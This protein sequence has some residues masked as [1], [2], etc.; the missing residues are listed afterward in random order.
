MRELYA[1]A[2]AGEYHRVLTHDIAAAKRRESDR[3]GLS[4]ADVAFAR[5]KGVR[6]EIN[7][8]PGGRSL[9]Q[10][11]RG[12]RRRVDLVLVVHFND[13]DVIGVTERARSAFDKL[14]QHVDADAHVR[15]VDDRDDLCVCAEL[16]LL[17]RVETGRSDDGC[18]TMLCT[19][20]NVR[21]R[22]GGPREVDQHIGSMYG[23]INV[24]PHEHARR[25]AKTFT[26]IM[27]EKCAV[28]DVERTHDV[29]IARLERCLDQR[30][31]H[32]PTCAG[33]RQLQRHDSIRE[34]VMRNAA[35]IKTRPSEYPK[36][37]RRIPCHQPTAPASWLFRRRRD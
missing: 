18:A 32:T 14:L 1:L 35:T 28:I 33:D 34:N 31:T 26:C 36:G 5:K 2:R 20:G 13:L 24:G 30:L 23:R 17:R 7:A 29:E 19:G 3:V 8:A 11:Q 16:R 10:L 15:R 25:A 27:R 9:S 12:T 21:H 6:G 37:D 4:R 22:A